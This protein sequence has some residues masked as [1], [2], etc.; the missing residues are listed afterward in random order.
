M[1]AKILIMKEC[2]R[3]GVIMGLNLSQEQFFC[4]QKQYL[5]GEKCIQDALPDMGCFQ[6]EFLMT[7][8]C[9]ECQSVIFGK[10]EADMTD[11]EKIT[12]D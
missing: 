8:Y 6:R 5:S 12:G 10:E 2:P 4:Y 11:F 3:C 1:S 9:P 7:G